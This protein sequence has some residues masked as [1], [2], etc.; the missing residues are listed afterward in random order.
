MI[1]KLKYVNY[2][3]VLEEVPDEIS[4]AINVSGCLYRCEGC[5]SAYLW[6][7]IGNYLE[8]DIEKLI[9]KYKD[10]I[11]CVCL[12]GGDHN[13]IEL[14]KVCKLIKNK[15]GLKVCIYSGHDTG[16]IFSTFI[17]DGILDYLK[18]GPYISKLGG[19]NSPITNQ[20]MFKIED[21]I[22]KDITKKFQHTP[23]TNNQ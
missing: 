23:L 20:R 7:Y 10:Y 12:M 8:D 14:Y 17:A 6:D 5:H 4:L 1:Q 2:G 9:D 16:D 13:I 21:G 22:M 18:I 3:I 15:Y 19:L 11:T